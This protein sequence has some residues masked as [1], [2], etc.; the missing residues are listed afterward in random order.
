MALCTAAPR[1]RFCSIYR[2]RPR[3]WSPATTV[4]R[5]PEGP[6]GPALGIAAIGSFIAG[7]VGVIGLTSSGAHR[8]ICVEVRAAGEICPGAA[9]PANGSD[10]FR[11]LNH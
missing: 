8:G 7:T 4:I 3:R 11:E 2:V 9:R 6:G 10:P 5:W 1:R